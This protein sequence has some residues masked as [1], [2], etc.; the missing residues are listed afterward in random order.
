MEV[1]RRVFSIENWLIF[2]SGACVRRFGVAFTQ[3]GLPQDQQTAIEGVIARRFACGTSTGPAVN[4]L[5]LDYDERVWS[6]RL[7]WQRRAYLR[8]RK[9]GRKLGGYSYFGGDDD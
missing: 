1:S 6:L 8:E 4:S 7:L 5:V 3:A 2:S 9:R